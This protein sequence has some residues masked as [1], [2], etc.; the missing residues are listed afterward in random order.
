MT[1]KRIRICFVI[2]TMEVGGTENQLLTLISSLDPKKFKTY[3]VCLK[4]S[5]TLR[6]IP[7]GS[8]K[9]VLDLNSFKSPKFI[10]KL[11]EFRSFL[12]KEQIEIVQAYF[13]DA[14]IFA[15][16]SAKLACVKKVISCRRDMGFWYNRRKLFTLRLLNGCVDRFLV[17]SNAI[18]ENM[19]KMEKVP[20][21]KIDVIYN[22]IR[23]ERYACDD[24]DERDRLRKE[25]K[26]PAD[27]IVVGCTANL[28]RKVK[29]VDRFIRAAALIS[30]SATKV[31]FLIIGDGCLRGELAGLANDLGIGDKIIFTGLRSDVAAL[32]K[33]IDIGVLTSDS[34]GISNS[35]LEY[36][37]AGIPAVV[38]DVGGNPE[39]IEDN[40][41]GF[42][43]HP[44]I[45]AISDSVLKLINN[46]EL[47]HTLGRNG[48]QKA[49]S[50]FSLKS[51]VQKTENYYFSLVRSN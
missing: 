10:F 11:L 35:I 5:N 22:G 39:L 36:M 31:S 50:I 49:C 2:D 24:A 37:A 43:V 8:E 16:L 33:M 32:L 27:H 44:E 30:R 3:L 17:N 28:N 15:I 18:K 12:R 47:R 38:T 9:I 1:E 42:L 25:F 40:R 20:L 48:R 26:I 21:D 45:E 7:A 46:P 6:D 13:F 41:E 34:E 4:H 19:S 51:M 14:N 23:P 29:R